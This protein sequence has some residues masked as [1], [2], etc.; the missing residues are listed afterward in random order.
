[1]V[2]EQH[3]FVQGHTMMDTWKFECDSDPG[4]IGQAY[5]DRF[6]DKSYKNVSKFGRSFQWKRK[7]RIV[8]IGEVIPWG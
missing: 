3:S 5:I 4:K 8:E 2:G 7:E 6:V 1:M